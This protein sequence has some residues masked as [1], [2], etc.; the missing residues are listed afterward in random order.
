[1]CCEEAQAGENSEIRP[2]DACER[3]AL[4]LVAVQRSK[5]L[6]RVCLVGLY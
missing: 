4:R 3:P 2:P 5:G 6:S 1:M